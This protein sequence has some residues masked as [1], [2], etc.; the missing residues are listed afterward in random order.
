MG[1]GN[2]CIWTVF[3][4]HMANCSS[5]MWFWSKKWCFPHFTDKVGDQRKENS[6]V[7]SPSVSLGKG[8]Q[9]N[10]WVGLWSEAVSAP[11][12]LTSRSQDHIAILLP[13]LRN[14]ATRSLVFVYAFSPHRSAWVVSWTKSLGSRSEGSQR[15]GERREEVPQIILPCV[16]LWRRGVSAG[17]LE[18]VVT[19]ISSKL[20]PSV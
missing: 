3:N 2:R 16:S 4:F 9:G 11:P 5:L 10:T 19:D 6:S 1:K 8:L 15:P 7:S 13:C 17:N 12:T 18:A 20:F 14:L